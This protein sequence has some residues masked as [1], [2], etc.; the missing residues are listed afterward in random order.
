MRNDARTDCDFGY[1]PSPYLVAAYSR[2]LKK[3]DDQKRSPGFSFFAAMLLC[4]E[5]SD[6]SHDSRFVSG[7]RIEVDNAFLGR[8]VDDGLRS[9]DQGFGFRSAGCRQHFFERRP[10][11]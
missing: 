3:P 9:I 4:L 5:C 11:R 10:Q 1:P 2:K 6:V 7:R 8:F